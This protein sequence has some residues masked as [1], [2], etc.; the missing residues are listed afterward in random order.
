[1]YISSLAKAVERECNIMTIFQCERF[2]SLVLSK[3]YLIGDENCCNQNVL[4]TSLHVVH[5]Y[6]NDSINTTELKKHD[7]ETVH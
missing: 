4:Y 5:W 7:S 2:N 1:M 3:T 6:E